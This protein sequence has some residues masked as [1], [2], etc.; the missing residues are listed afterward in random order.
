M[1]QPYTVLFDLDG[2]LLDTLGDITDAINFALCTLGFPEKTKAEVRAAVGNGL[3]KAIEAALP[4]AATM[5]TAA[6][7]GGEAATTADAA[8]DAAATTTADAVDAAIRLYRERYQE[9]Y[10]NRTQ[11]YPGIMDALRELA[12]RGYATVVLSNKSDTFTNNLVKHYFGGLVT[13]AAGER[14]GV[15]LKPAPDAVFDLLSRVG[16]DPGR[17]VYVGDS[18]VDIATAQNAGIPC[19]LVSWGFRGREELMRACCGAIVNA[20]EYAASAPIVDTVGECAASV[21]IVDTAGELLTCIY[22]FAANG[23]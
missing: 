10:M 20:D 3:R 1:P 4:D 11:P 21:P 8:A 23:A 6:A 15:P 14:P 18:E 22:T 9:C 2:T 16:G 17:A 7:T 12:G 19:I 13:A 5:A